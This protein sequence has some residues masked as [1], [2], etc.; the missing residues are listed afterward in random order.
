MRLDPR[1]QVDAMCWELID[2]KE[3]GGLAVNLSPIGV[4][5]ERPYTG[6]PTLYGV[7]L[8]LEV[9]DIDEVIWAKGEPMF[10]HVV[11]VGG[12]LVRRTGYRIV[13]AATRDLRM[14]RELVFDSYRA[15]VAKLVYP[16]PRAYSARYASTM[17]LAE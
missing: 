11:M 6:G 10:D 13:A 17:R 3:A 7:P 15:Q 9:P 4:R 1:L 5:I 2:G 16:R 12:Q 14:L 8:Q